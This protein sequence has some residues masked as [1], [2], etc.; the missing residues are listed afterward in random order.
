MSAPGR[1]LPPD[2]QAWEAVAPGYAEYWLP[3]FR[4]CLA[5]A[6]RAFA[7][8]PGRGR[9]FQF[10]PRSPRWLRSPEQCPH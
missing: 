8:G 10:P 9:L 7:P 6:L 3:R 2:V 4:P 1:E 5:A